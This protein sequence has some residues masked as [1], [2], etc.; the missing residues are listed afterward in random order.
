MCSFGLYIVFG[1]CYKNIKEFRIVIFK[2][3]N[4]QIEHKHILLRY[5][6]IHFYN[7]SH[8]MIMMRKFRKTE[9]NGIEM[10]ANEC[11]NKNL[12]DHVLV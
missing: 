1:D 4:C 11:L 2:I 9:I 8:G 5:E 6:T 3:R 7:N 12:T 10:K